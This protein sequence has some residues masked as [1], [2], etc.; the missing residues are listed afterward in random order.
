MQTICSTFR[1]VGQT[2]FFTQ[3]IFN[4]PAHEVLRVSY[5]DSDVSLVHGAS[6]HFWLVYTLEAT[7]SV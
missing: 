3:K 5:C 2:T 7:F 6:S 1:A 4:S